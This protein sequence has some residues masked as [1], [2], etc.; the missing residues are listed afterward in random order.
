M[1][2]EETQ[3]PWTHS[4]HLSLKSHSCWKAQ[5]C[6]NAMQNEEVQSPSSMSETLK[7]GAD[8]VFMDTAPLVFALFLHIST[9]CSI[10][11]TS[12]RCADG[13]LTDINTLCRL[14]F[15]TLFPLRRMRRIHQPISVLLFE[16]VKVPLKVNFEIPFLWKSWYTNWDLP[17][18]SFFVKR[19]ES[20]CIYIYIYYFINAQTKYCKQFSNN[21]VSKN[22]YSTLFDLINEVTQRI[23]KFYN[24]SYH[25]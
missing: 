24:T 2:K 5:R 19:L 15:C 23:T 9:L 22:F 1:Q 10:S 21:T 20:P 8:C 3:C 14:L 7:R 12:K 13:V 6:E 11:G 18:V 25:S 16:G 17:E 4:R